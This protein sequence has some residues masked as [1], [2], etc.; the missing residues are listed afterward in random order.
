[1]QLVFINDEVFMWVY[2]TAHANRVIC[3][4]N[5]A[6]SWFRNIQ[7][8][9]RKTPHNLFII[10]NCTPRTLYFSRL[11]NGLIGMKRW[12]KGH[13]VDAVTNII[14]KG[15]SL[16]T[17]GFSFPRSFQ[18]G[19]Y[20]LSGWAFSSSWMKS[21]PYIWKQPVYHSEYVQ[22][23]LLLYLCPMCLLLFDF[24]FG[25]E[26]ERGNSLTFSHAFFF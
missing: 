20:I 2:L 21:N 26:R 15:W 25:W 6:N 24:V 11:E 3:S 4:L 10:F 22:R 18:L 16:T 23:G 1:M 19:Q 13:E 8:K 14:S 9:D 7:A 12:Q 17:E 5:Y